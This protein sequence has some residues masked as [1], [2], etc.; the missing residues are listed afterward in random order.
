MTTRIEE[1]EE[2]P[3]A[4]GDSVLSGPSSGEVSLDMQPK[5]AATHNNWK[6]SEQ[7]NRACLY[8]NL[9]RLQLAQI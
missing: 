6:M 3:E 2:T 7:L 1:N 8:D 5:A 4:C 9:R